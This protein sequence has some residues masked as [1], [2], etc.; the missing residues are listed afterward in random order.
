M[1]Q[2]RDGAKRNSERKEIRET[3][4]IIFCN[5]PGHDFLLTWQLPPL[6]ANT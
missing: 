2:G 1:L 5:Q 3:G 4:D 6:P